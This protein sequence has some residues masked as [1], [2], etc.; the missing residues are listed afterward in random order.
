MKLHVSLSFK[1][2]SL[3]AAP[4]VGALIFSGIQIGR[5]A[6]AL[7]QLARVETAVDFDAELGE[8]HQALLAERRAASEPTGTIDLGIYRRRI[9]VTLAARDR[10][11]ARLQD[12]PP[13]ALARPGMTEAMTS[14]SAAQER[15]A[16]A[17]DT[18]IRP[19]V[20]APADA[21]A[22]YERYVGA[23]DELLTTMLL[24]AAESDSAPI[25]AR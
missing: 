10:L 13:A 8:L 18:F 9:E 22:A 23:A 1:L 6:L 5:Q 20:A 4:L 11:R 21:R 25:R 16:E 19:G 17:R 7:R 24:V 15:L 2:L 14:L 3:V 12:S